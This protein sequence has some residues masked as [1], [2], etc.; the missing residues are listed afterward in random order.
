[1]EPGDPRLENLKKGKP[2]QPG[3]DP[4]RNLDGPPKDVEYLKKFIQK[5]F[6]ENIKNEATGEDV[7]MLRAMLLKMVFS[8]A[9]SDHVALLQYGFGKVPDEIVFNLEDIKKIVEYLPDDMMQLLAKGENLTDVLIT[10]IKSHGNGT[11]VD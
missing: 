1:M 2:F 3:F 5:I 9:A 6:E 11:R 4:R 8:N 7:Q 10:F